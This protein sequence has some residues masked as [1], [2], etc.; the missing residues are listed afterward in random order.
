MGYP[1]TILSYPYLISVLPKINLLKYKNKSKIYF[2]EEFKNFSFFLSKNLIS[3]QLLLSARQILKVSGYIFP[4]LSRLL[5][6]LSSGIEYR[7]S[8]D[9]KYR[10]LKMRNVVGIVVRVSL[11]VKSTVLSVGLNIGDL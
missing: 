10:V 3:F 7:R 11:A 4:E 6:S 9:L 2:R 1:K 8:K 5:W